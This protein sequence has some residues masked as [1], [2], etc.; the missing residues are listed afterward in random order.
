MPTPKFPPGKSGNPQGRPK[1]KTPATLIRKAI[2]EEMPRIIQTVITA[3]KN[4]DMQAC[5]VLL[6]RVCPPLKAV[7]HPIHVEAGLCLSETGANVINAT[8]SGQMAPDIRDVST[9]FR[10]QG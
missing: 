9:V 3:A 7:A 4:G 8:L 5:K 1:D 10:T 2:A 6:D